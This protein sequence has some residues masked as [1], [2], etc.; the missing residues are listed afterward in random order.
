[1]KKKM[2]FKQIFL[3]FLGGCLISLFFQYNVF[4]KNENGE[5]KFSPGRMMKETPGNLDIT[6]P[7]NGS[8]FPADIAAPTF[9]WKENEN[10]TDNWYIVASIDGSKELVSAYSNQPHWKPN[11]EQ[12]NQLKQNSQWKKIRITV[13]ERKDDKILSS[14]SVTIQISKDKVGAKIFYRQVT[15]PFDYARKNL[16]TISWHLGDI[17]TDKPSTIML[18]NMPLCGNCHSFSMDGKKLGMDVDYANDK[19]SY[20]ILTLDKVTTLSPDKII[21]WSDYRREDGVLT[22][23]LLSQ[24]SPDGRYAPSIVKDRSI[25]VPKEDLFYSQLFF[26]IK[27]IL[28]VYDSVEQK[29]WAL[30]GADDPSYVQSNPTWTPDGKYIIFARAPAYYSEEAERS[31]MIVLPT[32][33]AAEFIEGRRDF[34]YDLYRIPFNDGKG[35]KAEPIPGASNNGMSN[36]FARV[37]PDGKWI[38]YTR[39]KNFMLLQPDS[40]LYIIPAAGGTAREMTCNTPA[41]NSWHS[42]SPNGKWLVFSSKALGAYTQLYL[43]HIDEE[44]R[45]TPPILLENLRSENRAA[46]IPEFVNL[47]GKEWEKIVDKFSNSDIYMIRLAENKFIKDDFQGSVEAYNKA[48]EKNPNDPTI[49]FKRADVKMALKDF[50]GAIDDYSKSIE[51]GPS[52]SITYKNRGDAK[53]RLGHYTEAMQDF[54]KAIQLQHKFQKAYVS[55]GDTKNML[56]DYRGALADLNQAITLNSEDAAAYKSRGDAFFGLGDFER[57]IEDYNTAQKIDPNFYMAFSSRG[58][59]K[60]ELKDFSGALSDINKAIQLYPENSD[61]YITRAVIKAKSGDFFGALE[62]IDKSI[63]MNPD[64]FNLYINRGIL[65]ENSGD[66]LGAVEDYSKAIQINPNYYKAYNHR[67]SARLKLKDIKE[68]FIDIDKA[69]QLN[70]NYSTLYLNRGNF[71]YKLNNFEQSINDYNKAI[72][73]S[74]E[75][76]KAYT[77]KGDAQ[78][79]LQDFQGALD[80]FSA[81]IRLNPKGAENYLR[82]GMMKVYL[83]GRREDVCSDFHKAVELG[84]KEAAKAI[85]RFCQ[86]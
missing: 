36:F 72:E 47:Q 55:R 76:A 74:P 4:S 71:Y 42:W 27:G 35:G 6:Y 26:P 24:I 12:W 16:E 23:G 15:L 31:K 8:L 14:G 32:S 21:S 70:P 3:L 25:F 80:S 48:V 30:P 85:E 18:A 44:G 37:S 22:F 2:S 86:E 61:L 66:F 57:A 20:A 53:Y 33:V 82:R 65:K 29:F 51:L 50:Q 62:D 84:S 34:K 68:A 40:R 10:D 38:V 13:T 17:T 19:G 79:K 69:I 54:N 45:D 41:M 9:R 60:S 73:L 56:N 39:A 78:Y 28:G 77:Y 7:L 11:P 67:S 81:A 1:M 75:Y 49:Y 64:N 59:L 46:N 63:Q 52:F 43:T 83:K 58:E 5:Y